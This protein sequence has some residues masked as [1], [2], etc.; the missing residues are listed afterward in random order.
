MKEE[1]KVLLDRLEG[2]P[3]DEEC[4]DMAL[5]LWSGCYYGSVHY[6]GSEVKLMDM[7]AKLTPE[8]KDRVYQYIYWGP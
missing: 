7:F 4:R 1:L 5:L 8:Q 6:D 2:N 3:T